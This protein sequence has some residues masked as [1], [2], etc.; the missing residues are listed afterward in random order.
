MKK[1]FMWGEIILIAIMGAVLLA[2][3]GDKKKENNVKNDTNVSSNQNVDDNNLIAK[4]M[5]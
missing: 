5:E 4:N 1:V 3:C 2:G